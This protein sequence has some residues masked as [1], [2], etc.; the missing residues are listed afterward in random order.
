MVAGDLTAAIAV[1]GSVDGNAVGAYVLT[2]AVSDPSG[3]TATATRTVTV[4]DTTP[5]VLTL[6]G[7]NPVT[8][9]GGTLFVDPGATAADMVAGDLT[10]AIAVSGSVDGNAVGAYVLTYAV[11]DPSGNTATATRTVTVVDT[12]P[13]VLTVP[14][15]TVLEAAGP[16]GTVH[17]FSATAADLVDAAPTVVCLPPSG[18][19]FGVGEITVNCTATD[20][21][22]NSAT[23]AFTVT[24]VDTTPPVLTVP[25]DIVLEATGLLTPVSLGTATAT[26]LADPSPVLTNDAPPAFPIGTTVVTWT[27]TDAAG[28]SASATQSVTVADTTPPD[29]Q[30]VTASPEVLWPANH[31]MVP[32][33]VTVAAT[34]VL[35]PPVCRVDYVGSNEPANGT[36][37]G[38]AAPDVIVTG[39][40]A[41]ELRAER[42][43]AGSGRIYT[44]GIACLDAAGNVSAAEVAILVPHNATEGRTR[45]GRE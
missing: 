21:S 43:G 14:P 16:G 5:P 4:V 32:V 7:A 8:L 2:Y 45:R 44:V 25:A 10:A 3:N 26:D 17:A 33:D 20:A 29:I 18:S 39:E 1:S 12:T 15:D 22:G 38:D 31:Q 40:L 30:S 36:G 41:L 19:T 28:N 35:D 13:P 23:G 34:D 9:E 11:S 27:A 6:L 24:I 37:D 42:S